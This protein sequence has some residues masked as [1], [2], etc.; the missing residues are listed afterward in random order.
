MSNFRKVGLTIAVAGATATMVGTVNSAGN[1]LDVW[2]SNNNE[3]AAAQGAS[4]CGNLNNDPTGAVA[5]CVARGEDGV[6]SAFNDAGDAAIIPYY[7]TVGSFVTG[8][9]VVNT[10]AAT[11]AVK[12]RL[13][14]ATCLLYTSP[15]PRD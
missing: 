12:I 14:R 13:R 2:H 8:M 7:T 4:D 9:H 15:S 1:N 5:D 6:R 10:S 11:Q 3:N